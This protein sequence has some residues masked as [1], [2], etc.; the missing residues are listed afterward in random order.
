VDKLNAAIRR[1]V[2][3]PEVQEL[4][5]SVGSESFTN[6]PEELAALLKVELERWAQVVKRAGIKIE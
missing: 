6:S 2:Q 5:Q 4:L 3:D 1:S